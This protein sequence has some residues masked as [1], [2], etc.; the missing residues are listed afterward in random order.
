MI[1][2]SSKLSTRFKKNILSEEDSNDKELNIESKEYSEPSNEQLII[3][4]HQVSCSD[5]DLLDQLLNKINTI[6][7]WNDYEDAKQINLVKNFIDSQK[8]NISDDKKNAIIEKLFD[9]I[10]GFGPIENL[11]KNENVSS[12]LING[13]KKVYI[14]MFGKMHDTEIVLSKTQVDFIIKNILRICSV[15]KLCIKKVFNFAAGG[16]MFSIISSDIS[17][18][19]TIISIRK[20]PEFTVDSFMNSGIMSR[21]IFDF[22]LSIVDSGKNIVIS[23]DINS[24]KTFLLGTLYNCL[25]K[26]KRGAL[27]QEFP[28]IS[29]KFEDSTD[30]LIDVKSDDYHKFLD[31]ILKFPYEV[32]FADLNNYVPVLIENKGL[33]FSLRSSSVE[34][35]LAKMIAAVMNEEKCSDKFAKH[36]IL[37]S[38]DYLIQLNKFS[39][40]K[41][42]LTSIVELTPART[43][44]LSVK[45]IVKLVDGKYISEIPQ[46]LTSIRAQA[47]FSQSGLM[48][49]RFYQKN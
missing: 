17:I 8:L 23:G 13:N 33:I 47:A 26:N 30:F 45:N 3:K 37:D 25:A 43:N 36:T 5:E 27:I 1:L 12:I 41:I 2:Q 9:I 48:S 22:I 32:V 31:S 29:N 46:P 34:N 38:C 49:S 11:L 21:E 14:E 24:G 28:Q 10:R 44:A 35:A 16:Y 4:Q 19:G 42:K 6:P 18:S 20:I 39:D 15:D 7:V 40:G